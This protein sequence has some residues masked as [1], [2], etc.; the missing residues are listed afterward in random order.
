MAYLSGKGF[1]LSSLR[2]LGWLVADEDTFSQRSLSNVQIARLA[3]FE[4]NEKM[5][6]R[7]AATRS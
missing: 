2:V 7:C 6:G 5:G 4:V 1:S 3:L